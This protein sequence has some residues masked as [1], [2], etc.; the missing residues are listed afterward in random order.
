MDILRKTRKD[1]GRKRAAHD[2]A[3]VQAYLNGAEKP[4]NER[5]ARLTRY[6]FE[7]TRKQAPKDVILD[8]LESHKAMRE[9]GWKPATSVKVEQDLYRVIM[10]VN[11]LL[12][13]IANGELMVPSGAGGGYAPERVE[14]LRQDLE[15]ITLT[16][17]LYGNAE[18][19]DED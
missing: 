18:F 13:A 6:W 9:D 19:F 2:N 12:T 3:H 4:G 8:A 17:D 14:S 1:K 15:G 11:D 5:Q 7:L 10:G 16:M